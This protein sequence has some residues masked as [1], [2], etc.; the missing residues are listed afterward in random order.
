VPGI[1]GAPV[2]INTYHT[3]L[4]GL[5]PESYQRVEPGYIL[6][7]TLQWIVGCDDA[8]LKAYF[9]AT[10]KLQEEEHRGG[11]RVFFKGLFE[12]NL[13]VNWGEACFAINTPGKYTITAEQSNDT[14][15]VSRDK[16]KVKTAVG[17]IRS[18]PLTLTIAE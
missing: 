10:K 1:N 16:P 15:L 3:V 12:R 18:S 17:T 5:A 8:D 6:S 14:V 9:Q 11:E 2:L 4:E 7:N 13:F